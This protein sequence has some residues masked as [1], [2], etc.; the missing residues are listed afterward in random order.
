MMKQDSRTA[1]R[2]P[3][4]AQPSTRNAPLAVALALA[5]AWTASCHEPETGGRRTATT[6]GTAASGAAGS[7]ATTSGVDRADSAGAS[8]SNR[9]GDADSAAA[10]IRRY[11]AAIA[12]GRY[13]EAYDLW[14]D[15]GRNSGQTFD[16][17]SAGFRHT[18]RVS[19]AIGAPGRVEGAAGSRYVEIPV[20]VRAL[21]DSG[22]RQ[23][24]EGTYT[25]R[26]AVIE[27]ASAADRRW[28]LYAG[29]LEAAR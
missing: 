15:G 10:V 6:S 8:A 11:Y 17:F 1:G 29:Q 16:A 23:R 26:R 14:G 2:A 25:L 20:V 19:V 18:A 4:R 3:T 12:A 24:F 7:G 27:G 9:S 5:L 21:T 13:R 22:V 28:H